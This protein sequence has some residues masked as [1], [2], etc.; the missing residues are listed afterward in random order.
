M[1]NKIIFSLSIAIFSL[2]LFFQTY[3]LSV[4]KTKVEDLKST[5]ENQQK[6]NKKNLEDLLLRNEELK[7]AQY[8]TNLLQK[9]IDN[10][11]KDDACFDEPLP[12]DVIKLLQEHN[13]F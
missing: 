4:E 13:I 10:L 9:K 7:N 6:Q 3:R 11:A 8:K 5:V 1:K 2:L 12:P